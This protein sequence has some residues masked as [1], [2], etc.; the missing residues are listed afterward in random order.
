MKSLRT[1]RFWSTSTSLLKRAPPPVC[2]RG[3]SQIDDK[4]CKGRVCKGTPTPRLTAGMNPACAFVAG[5]RQ[6]GLC[7]QPQSPPAGTPAGGLFLAIVHIIPHRFFPAFP[8]RCEAD[9]ANRS[10]TSNSTQIH[11]SALYT[12]QE[13]ENTAYL[14]LQTKSSLPAARHAGVGGIHC[15]R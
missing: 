12:G 6:R 5:C 10:D 13:L 8:Q 1:I 15:R 3:G 11:S 9:A 7:Q 2:R 14:R 4:P